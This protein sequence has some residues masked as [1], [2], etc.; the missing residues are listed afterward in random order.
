M[1]KIK[2]I[3]ECMPVAGKASADEGLQS[4]ISYKH[5]GISMRYW[6]AM[7]DPGKIEAFRLAE[8]IAS[9]ELKKPTKKQ[10]AEYYSAIVKWCDY[11]FVEYHHYKSGRKASKEYFLNRDNISSLIRS[12][13]KPLEELR[14]EKEEAQKALLREE[15]RRRFLSERGVRFERVLEENLKP[16]SVITLRE[17][18]GKYG[19]FEAKNTY[20][21]PIYYSGYVL[22]EENYKIYEEKFK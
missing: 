17:M 18:H 11:H 2:K 4:G 14:K 13:P 1:E 7:N 6:S 10:I 22:S 15:E 21:L 8:I 3:I 9:E 5:S 16:N 19:W 20:N 12:W